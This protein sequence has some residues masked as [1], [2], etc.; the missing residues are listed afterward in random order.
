MEKRVLNDE[1]K[2]ELLGLVPFAAGSTDDFTP[3]QY[4]K[5]GADGGYLIPEE[6][7]PVFKVRSFTVEEKRGVAKLLVNIKDSDDAAVVEAARKVVV[8]WRNLFDSGSG[9]EIFFK[10]AP[11]G[12]TD[13]D[14]FSGIP[15]AIVGA[16]LF[17][18]SRISGIIATEKLS[19][20]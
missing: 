6:Y 1:V 13:A 11:G 19:L 18:A 12:G 16:L 15:A 8:G 9:E 17:H 3:P 2:R 14:L 7:R 5:T 4:L 10:S 20:K